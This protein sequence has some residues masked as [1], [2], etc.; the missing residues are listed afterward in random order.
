MK[1]GYYL[2]VEGDLLRVVPAK[3][4]KPPAIIIFVNSAQHTIVWCDKDSFSKHLFID[5]YL[6]ASL[7]LPYKLLKNW[8]AP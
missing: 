5:S 8:K 3:N 6:L 4:N 1:P 7:H 2:T